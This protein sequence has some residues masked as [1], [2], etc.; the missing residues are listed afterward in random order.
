MEVELEED[1][2]AEPEVER[3]E[4]VGDVVDGDEEP[5]EVEGSDGGGVAD[6]LEED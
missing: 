6:F 1:G 3:C 4:P 2:V 5:G